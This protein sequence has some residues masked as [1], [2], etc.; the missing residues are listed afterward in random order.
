VNK[1]PRSPNWAIEPEKFQICAKN[2][3]AA[4]QMS[5]C[6]FFAVLI[7]IREHDRTVETEYHRIHEFAEEMMLNTI[8]TIPTYR[9]ILKVRSGP[10]DN[11]VNYL[12]EVA[13]LKKRELS[14]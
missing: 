7:A 9:I 5:V 4:L 11:L 12:F 3:A 1:N 2:R 14:F 10:R 8:I 6:E 13:N